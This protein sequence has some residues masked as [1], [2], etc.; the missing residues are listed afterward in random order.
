VRIAG[1][2]FAFVRFVTAARPAGAGIAQLSLR[3]K[4][5]VAASFE[6]GRM[7]SICS[8]SGPCRR[9]GFTLIELMIVLV[10]IAI[11]AALAYPSYSRYVFRSRVV[12]GLD[13]L[14]ALANRLEQ[15]YQDVGGYGSG[16]DGR[17]DVA[18]GV[19]LS[20]PPNFTL[21]CAPSN[22]G[23]HF[24]ATA[25]GSGA[26][27]GV[28]YTIDDTGLRKTTAHPFG[29]PPAECWSIKGAACDS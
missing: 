9:H 11:L 6:D 18:C 15:R 21:A 28:V 10:V 3:F 5:T 24:E 8:S 14:G 25:T 4:T 19:T 13:A 26:A 22:S 29:L 1:A 16:I 17:N 27:T 20:A 23:A 7:P 12:P 2:P